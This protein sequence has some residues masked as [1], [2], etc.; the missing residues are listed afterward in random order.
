MHTRVALPGEV[1]I[2]VPELREPLKPVQEEGMS[3]RGLSSQVHMNERR[4]Y[5]RKRVNTT[6]DRSRMNS[7]TAIPVSSSPNWVRS[8]VV[9]V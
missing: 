1:E 8:L 4:Q 7:R 6:I 3:V 9:L 5:L 2:V